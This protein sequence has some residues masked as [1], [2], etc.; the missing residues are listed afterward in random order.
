MMANSVRVITAPTVEPVTITECKLDARVDGSTEDTLFTTLIAAA[1]Q[2][3]ENAA[4]R[5]L[6]SRTLEL[7]LDMWPAAR[8][9][10]LPYPPLASVTS[11]KYSDQDNVVQTWSASSYIAVTDEE[12]GLILLADNADWPTDLH[13]YPRIRIRY[14]A[15]YGAAASAVPDSYKQ[16]IRGLVKLQYDY[17]S[18]WTPDAERARAIILAHASVEWGW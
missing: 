2:E 18:G 5:A 11:I 4:R 1:R 7:A 14:V 15:G 17:R 12:P 10:Q 3:I 9:I 8:H 6:I 13:S 16:D